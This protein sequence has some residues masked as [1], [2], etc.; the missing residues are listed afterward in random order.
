MFICL[1]TSQFF[2]MVFV[3]FFD[4]LNVKLILL[5]DSLCFVN[6]ICLSDIFKG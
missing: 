5:M 6:L 1:L 3:K 4:T 2:R